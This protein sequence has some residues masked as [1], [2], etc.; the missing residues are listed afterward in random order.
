[1]VKGA[2]SAWFPDSPTIRLTISDP[3]GLQLG[4]QGFLAS[5][6]DP[7]DDSLSVWTEVLNPPSTLA[8][9][10]DYKVDFEV[11]AV[12]PLTDNATYVTPFSAKLAGTPFS[13]VTLSGT[14]NINASGKDDNNVLN[15]NSGIN[16]LDGGAGDDTIIGGGGADT[17]YAG[18]GNDTYILNAIN[19]AGS[20]IQDLDGIDSFT[21]ENAQ[22][23]LVKAQ[24]GTMGLGRLNTMLIVDLNQDGVLNP[25]TDLSILNF[26]SDPFSNT[27]GIGFLDT[28][29]NIS[30]NGVLGL[31]LLDSD[32]DDL[33]SPVYRFFNTVAGGHFFTTSTSERDFVLNNL[34]QYLFEGVGF[35]ASIVDGPNL[36]PIY[37]F[38]NTV[39]G[40]HFFTASE[41]ERDFVRNNLSQYVDEGIGFYAYGA[42]ANLGADV[43]RFF[44]T[45]A[46]GHFFTT[47]ASERDL[48]LNSQPQYLFEGIGFEAGLA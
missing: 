1:M 38:F 42:D 43:F 20:S 22:I 35:N 44:N 30:G 7:N 47:S 6:L 19:A 14:G 17:L 21:L 36:I 4:L 12:A 10:T 15:G 33:L 16:T 18:A 13:N 23:A 41:A 9:G 31:E 5:S 40:G 48:V 46:G 26:Y 8:Q 45:V 34:P 29:D 24:P 2:G 37:R 28:I 39:A 32:I 3:D 11:I 25:D 27:A